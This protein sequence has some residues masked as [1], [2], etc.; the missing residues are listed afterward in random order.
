MSKDDEKEIRK[1]YSEESRPGDEE[2]VH[3]DTLNADKAKGRRLIINKETGKITNAETGEEVSDIQVVTEDGSLGSVSAGGRII[4]CG[5]NAYEM[6]YYF[7]P[8]FKKIP[9]SI[10]KELHIISVLFTQEAGGIFTIEFED[11]GSITME[12]TRDDED[13]TY[14][15]VSAGLLIGEVRRQRQD[16]F[17]ALQMYYRAMILHEDM[18]DIL[19][20]DD[21]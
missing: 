6:K 7:N 15:E 5:A 18:S 3:S 1:V 20:E 12:T 10:Q 14:D 19:S 8:L 4:L 17:E 9:E 2:R 21:E 13:I 16:L 11:D